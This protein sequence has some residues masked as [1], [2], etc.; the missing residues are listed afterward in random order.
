[1]N[2]KPAKLEKLD[3]A[4]VDD[5]VD[6][7]DELVFASSASTSLSSSYGTTSP[8][9]S[10]PVATPLQRPPHRQ[11]QLAVGYCVPPSNGGHL[12]PRVRPS[13]YF[14]SRL[15]RPPKCRAAVLSPVAAEKLA[16][17]TLVAH[18]APVL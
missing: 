17:R 9:R 16:V 2:N 15:I 11:R 12:R 1:M 18:G 3:M 5:A 10:A 7:L 8:T 14:F 6:E 4:D 13:I